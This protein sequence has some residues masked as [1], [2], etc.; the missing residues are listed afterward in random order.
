VPAPASSAIAP[1]TKENRIRQVPTVSGLIQSQGRAHGATIFV[2]T[3]ND[4][5]ALL[6]FCIADQSDEISAIRAISNI[7]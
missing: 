5:L 4:P 3:L 2:H 7:H 6:P 1:S